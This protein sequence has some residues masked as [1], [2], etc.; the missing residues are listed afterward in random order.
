MFVMGLEIDTTKLK[1]SMKTA[2]PISISAIVFPFLT[3]VAA[4]FWIYQVNNNGVS[5]TSF[6]LF[7]GTSM[8]F[9]AFPVLAAILHSFQLINHPIG[10]LAFATAAV[11]DLLAWCTLAIASAFVSSDNPIL[12][13]YTL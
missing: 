13:V 3:G 10:V 5:Q 12:G 7:F 1:E 8:S 4:S 9:T 6:I 2:A 11:D